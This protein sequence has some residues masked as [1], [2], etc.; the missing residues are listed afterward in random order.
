MTSAWV[1]Y[2]LRQVTKPASGTRDHR[3]LGVERG[4]SF[5]T[6][7]YYLFKN[8]LTRKNNFIE[9]IIIII[10]ESS[11]FHQTRYKNRNS[12]GFSSWQVSI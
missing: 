6:I 4:L 1:R 2:N 5:L 12:V 11:S 3:E 8:N 10:Y 9:I 7:F